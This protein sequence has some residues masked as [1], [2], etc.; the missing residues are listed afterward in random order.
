MTGRRVLI[1]TEVGVVVGSSEQGADRWVVSLDGG[2][3]VVLSG[4]QVR[5]GE[6]GCGTRSL[7]SWYVALHVL[8]P[9]TGLYDY[10]E[11]F[12]CSARHRDAFIA[13]HRDDPGVE[14]IELEE[15][16]VL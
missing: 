8:D 14:L 13:A 4:Q 10:V 11:R 3:A 6:C 1:G 16:K 2:G 12:A 7:G 15:V 9:A 5:E